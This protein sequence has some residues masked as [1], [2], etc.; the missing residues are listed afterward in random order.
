MEH[1]ME[2]SQALSLI[3]DIPNFPQPGILFKDIT[4]LLADGA[5]FTSIA[6]ALADSDRS[7]TCVAG[8][9]ARGFI[10]G[11]AIALSRGVG[12]IPLRKA[13][14]LPYQTI[15]K[16]YG[17]EYGTDVIE[18]HI[19]A[20]GPKD[21]VL[22]VDDVLATGGT[23]LAAIEIVEELGGTIAEVVVIF[24]IAALGGRDKIAAKYPHINLRSLV[25]A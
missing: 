17:L 7:Y 8:I 18:A 2:L 19:D 20:V 15:A 16:S 25:K 12:F 11:S 5:A 24:E 23:L 14:K 4:P 22:I 9:E 10:V 1:L 6:S 21:Q 13:G 3:R